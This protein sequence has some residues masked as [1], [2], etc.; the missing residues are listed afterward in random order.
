M[1]PSSRIDRAAYETA[2]PDTVTALLALGRAVADSGLDEQLTELLKIRASQV[3]GCAFCLRYHLNQARKLGT[4]PAKLDLVSTW[5]EA[6]IYSARECAAFAWTDALTQMGTR[7]IDDAAYA[8]LVAHFS[9]EEIAHLTAAIA[10]I[11]AWNRIAGGLRFAPPIP[12]EP[13]VRESTA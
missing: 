8:N 13:R 4:P 11:N 9:T 3:N 6:G 5:A 7:S 10:N 12:S 2:A 1:N